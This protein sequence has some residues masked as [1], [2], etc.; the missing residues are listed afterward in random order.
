MGV[1]RVRLHYARSK[2]LPL[3]KNSTLKGSSCQ[4]RKQEV[5]RVI[6]FVYGGIPIHLYTQ[7]LIMNTCVLV[8][9]ARAGPRSAIGRAPD[10]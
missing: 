5:T 7:C 6:S 9:T 1:T 8:H 10:S 4:E 3:R 2:F